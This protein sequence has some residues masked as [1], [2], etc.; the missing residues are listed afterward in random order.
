MAKKPET[1]MNAGILNVWV[2]WNTHVS[3]NDVSTEDT[4]QSMLVE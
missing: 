3:R 2:N 1:I 4:S